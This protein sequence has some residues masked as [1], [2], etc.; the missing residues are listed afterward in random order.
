MEGAL[1]YVGVTDRSVLSD[2]M[3]GILGRHLT[4]R[5]EKLQRLALGY[6][7]DFL[8]ERGQR[9][10][11]ARP[12]A[13]VAWINRR[14]G[15]GIRHV[16]IKGHLRLL[17]FMQLDGAE[18]VPVR[19]LPRINVPYRGP[20][21]TLSAQEVRRL[22]EGIDRASANGSR[23]FVVYSLLYRLGLRVGEVHALDITDIDLHP[24]PKTLRNAVNDHPAGEILAEFTGVEILGKH[25]KWRQ[26]AA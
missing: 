2:S 11:Q 13:A 8:A 25:Q 12:G 20:V 17:R 26:T 4:E 16:T 22:F 14:S 21:Q 5:T 24:S 6:F 15:E 9:M 19:E 7:R 23:D 18:Q 1:C 3:A 10:E